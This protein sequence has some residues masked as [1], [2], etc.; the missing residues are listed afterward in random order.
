MYPLTRVYIYKDEQRFFGEGPCRLLHAID[1]TGSLRAAAQKMGLSYSKALTML[2]RAEDM[3]QIT[4]TEKSIGGKGGGGSC[5]T[6]EAWDFLQKY[7]RFRD[8]CYKENQKIFQEIF[9]N[10]S[11]KIGCVIMASGQGKRF[12]SNKLLAEFQGK[13]L[14]QRTLD[15]TDKLFA[16]RVVV[17]RCKEVEE[18]C[19]A[20]NVPVIFHELP[21]RSDTVRLGVEEMLSMDGCMFC[22]CDQPVLQRDSLRQMLTEFEQGEKSIVRLSYADKVGAPVLFAQHY[23]EQLRQLPLHNGGSYVMKQYPQEV[24]LAP[25]VSE[26]ELFDID[27]QE[28]LQ[29]LLQMTVQ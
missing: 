19:K 4:L 2:H 5:L 23:F 12:G 21:D 29:Y 25:A 20:Q 28:D 7:E 18:L 27:T 14:I 13:S 6:A 10:P 1:E 3:L 22:P 15:L 26:W 9:Q 24:L 16:K 8:A 17:T 11:K